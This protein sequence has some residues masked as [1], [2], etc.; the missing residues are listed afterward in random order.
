M[1]GRSKKPSIG[2]GFI[3]EESAH[4]FVLSLPSKGAADTILIEERY[5]YGEPEEQRYPEAR[6][7]VNSYTWGRI[8]DTVQA[9]FNRRLKDAGRKTSKFCPGE[10]LLAPYLGKELTLLLWALAGIDATDLPNALANWLGFAPEERWWLY[11]TVKTSGA[12]PETVLLRG[13]RKAICIAFA[14]APAP[15]PSEDGRGFITETGLQGEMLPLPDDSEDVN[16]KKPNRRKKQAA[17]SL[18]E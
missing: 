11:T 3:P 15:P 6:A 7:Q 18:F 10:N 8:A 14:E 13:W 1:V 9:Q 4:H 16:A 17:L 2:F 5:T 12:E